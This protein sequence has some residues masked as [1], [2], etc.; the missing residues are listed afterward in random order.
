MASLVVDHS[1]RRPIRKATPST[2]D[3]Q[4]SVGSSP[5]RSW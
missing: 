4:G 3:Q 5:Q 2:R 1:A